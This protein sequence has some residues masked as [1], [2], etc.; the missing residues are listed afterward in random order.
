MKIAKEIATELSEKLTT[1]LLK[2]FKSIMTRSYKERVLAAQDE[3]TQDIESIIAAKLE[4]VKRTFG[5]ILESTT[6]EPFDL[7]TRLEMVSNLA[8]DILAL[9]KEE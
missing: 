9:F 5:M 8:S 3:L 6:D 2:A 7:K 1:G 4:L